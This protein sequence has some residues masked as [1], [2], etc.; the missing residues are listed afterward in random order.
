MNN[1]GW[2]CSVGPQAYGNAHQNAHP[3][4]THEAGHDEHILD[5]IT[6][7]VDQHYILS[8]FNILSL[9]QNDR[10]FADDASR[11]ISLMKGANL[12]NT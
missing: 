11:C 1:N 6:I 2:S 7:V 9:V 3:T 4:P 12:R 5:T 10:H 8:H